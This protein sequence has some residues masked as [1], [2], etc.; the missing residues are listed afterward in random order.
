[1]DKLERFVSEATKM[2]RDLR[3]LDVQGKAGSAEMTESGEDGED[4][5]RVFRCKKGR[6]KEDGDG[7]FSVQGVTGLNCSKGKSGWMSR[8]TFQL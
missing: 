3:K 4:L 2:I 6:Y 1:M 5:K 7:L 8:R